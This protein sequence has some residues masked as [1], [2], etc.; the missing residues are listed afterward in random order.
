MR[1]FHFKRFPKD[2]AMVK[3]G[4]KDVRENR[5]LSKAEL[6]RKANVSVLTIDRIESGKPCRLET[7]RKILLALG[8]PFSEKETIFGE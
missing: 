1:K 4:L 8:M 5:L 6:A 2:C 3:K 7:K